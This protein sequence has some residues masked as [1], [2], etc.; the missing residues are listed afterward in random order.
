MTP[1]DIEVLIHY[2]VCPEP[3]P[4]I[5]FQAIKESVAFFIKIG[6]LAYT[7]GYYT[8]TAK[9]AAH[10]RQI[11]NLELPTQAWVG[12]NGKIIEDEYK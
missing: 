6:L 5:E 10:I 3:H 9:G 2:H 8:T 12:A 1:S 11:C 4:R 7:D